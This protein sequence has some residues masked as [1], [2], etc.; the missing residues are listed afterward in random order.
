MSIV[1]KGR[2]MQKSWVAI[3]MIHIERWIDHFNSKRGHFSITTYSYKSLEICNVGF[4]N[5][6]YIVSNIIHNDIYIAKLLYN[7][8][9][10]I[11]K[12]LFLFYYM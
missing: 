6:H 12:L 2:S 10:F 3:L 5:F 11:I 9:T 7:I 1:G 4:L 8:N